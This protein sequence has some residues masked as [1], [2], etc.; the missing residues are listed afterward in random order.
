MDHNVRV[1]QCV[2]DFISNESTRRKT[3]HPAIT[4]LKLHPSVYVKS[5]ALFFFTLTDKT[6]DALSS[7]TGTPNL[8]PAPYSWWEWGLDLAALWH[9]HCLKPLLWR[10]DLML[11]AGVLQESKPPPKVQFA[12][13]L[14][15]LFSPRKYQHDATLF[16][17]SLYMLSRFCCRKA[18]NSIM[19][20]PKL[21]T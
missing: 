12:S 7:L 1:W 16:H 8:S 21:K 13:S 2:E 18:S 4:T 6:P 15:P 20:P 11:G 3:L 10:F 19:Q 14:Q 9:Y 17:F 5:K